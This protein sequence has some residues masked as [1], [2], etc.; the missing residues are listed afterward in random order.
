MSLPLH[1]GANDIPTKT[2]YLPTPPPTDLGLRIGLK[3]GLVWAGNPNHARDRERSRSLFEF[4]PLRARR[5]AT[6][7]SL[8]KGHALQQSP[9]DGMNLLDLGSGFNDMADT[10]AAMRSLDLVISIDSAPAHLA[11]ALD[12]PVW[13]LLP[14]IPD[15]RW[16]LER[17]DTPWYPRM[18]LFREREGWPEVFERVA[19]ALADFSPNGY[20]R[21]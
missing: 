5:D 19:E 21:Q 11:G 2:P 13:V 7:Y 1:Y 4:A 3:V 10:A 6:F 18:R 9:P 15:W 17:E 8:Q 20:Q 16:G 14:R 12:V